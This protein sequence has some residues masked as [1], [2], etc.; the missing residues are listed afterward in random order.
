MTGKLT[1]VDFSHGQATF[2][3]DGKPSEEVR[4]I[5]KRNGFRW[6]PS[7]GYWWRRGVP[8]SVE[9]SEAI[10]KVENRGK[11]DGNCHKC[12]QPGR[13]RQ[14]AARTYLYCDDCNAELTSQW[15]YGPPDAD[16]RARDLAADDF[17]LM[18]NRCM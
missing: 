5:L 7:C 12:G 17:D 1:A 13:W 14:Y 3:F 2:T 15:N 9:I 4:G 6:S 18:N 8:G 10:H 16:Q 11:P